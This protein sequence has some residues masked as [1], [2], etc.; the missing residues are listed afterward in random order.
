MDFAS[1]LVREFLEKKQNRNYASTTVFNGL[2]PRWL[3][4]LQKTEDTDESKAICYDWGAKRK[5]E[6]GAVG[7]TKS[8]FQ[9]CFE[10]WKTR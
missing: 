9:K 1:M 7:D 5:I 2:G 4:S 8:K 10:D 3:F 6:T